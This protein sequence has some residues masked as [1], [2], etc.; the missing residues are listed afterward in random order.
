MMEILAGL[1]ELNVR[2]VVMWVIGA[3]MIDLAIRK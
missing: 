2:M 3:V 1:A